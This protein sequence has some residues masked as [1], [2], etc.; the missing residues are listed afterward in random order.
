MSGSSNVA[1]MKKVVQQLRLEASVTRVKVS[2]AAVD[3]KQFCLQNAQH[4]PLLTGV[5]SSTNPFR[6]Q[7][8][9]SFL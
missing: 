9:C 3:L 2:Q 6:P 1:A 5:S 8:V 4:D 7:K